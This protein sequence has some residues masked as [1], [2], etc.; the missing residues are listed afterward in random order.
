MVLLRWQA[1]GPC[2]DGGLTSSDVEFWPVPR[3]LGR[4]SVGWVYEAFL[5]GTCTPV[6]V[7][8]LPLNGSENSVPQEVALGGALHE[9]S[10][11]EIV[12]RELQILMQL[13]RH[14][15]LVRCFGGFVAAPPSGYATRTTSGECP[16]RW[17]RIEL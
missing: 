11:S 17:D 4:G 14:Q 5:R 9:K 2:V 6:A 3:E 12:C 1:S 7:K 8:I 10:A 15:N 16:A 13:P